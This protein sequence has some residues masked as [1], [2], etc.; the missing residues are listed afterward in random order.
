VNSKKCPWR[1]L[2]K[3][4]HEAK[5]ENRMKECEVVV[6]MDLILGSTIATTGNVQFTGKCLA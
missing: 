5:Y 4:E 1:G 6:P 3:K 2:S